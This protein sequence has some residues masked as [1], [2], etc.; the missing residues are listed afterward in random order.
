MKCNSQMRRLVASQTTHSMCKIHPTCHQKAAAEEEGSGKTKRRSSLLPSSKSR[1]H[2]PSLLA[3]VSP[4][5][6]PPC[7]FS[8]FGFVKFVSYFYSSAL[9]ALSASQNGTGWK[10]ST[11]QFD[12]HSEL[13][14]WSSHYSSCENVKIWLKSVELHQILWQSSCLSCLPILKSNLVCTYGPLKKWKVWSCHE[15]KTWK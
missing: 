2:A 4:F 3:Q 14:Q 5:L 10:T 12:L 15:V 13:E 9:P 8:K 7:L 1:T 6:Y 11:L